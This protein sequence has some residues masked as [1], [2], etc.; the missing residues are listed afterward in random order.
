MSDTI[1]LADI[2]WIQIIIIIFFVVGPLLS[3]LGKN[4][5]KPAQPP[6]GPKRQPAP[7]ALGR[8]KQL[9]DEIDRLLRQA[10]DAAARKDAEQRRARQAIQ[11]RKP[12]SVDRPAAQSP[13]R[14]RRQRLGAGVDQHVQEHIASRPVTEHSATLGHDIE[15][16]DEQ[17]ERHLQNVFEHQLGNLEREDQAATSF[18]SK[19]SQGTDAAT[20]RGVTGSRE[21]EQAVLARRRTAIRGLFRDPE[22]IRNAFVLGEILRGPKSLE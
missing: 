22:Q 11:K 20:W 13:D 1:V 15:L 4:A 2:N 18:T 6:R 5:E 7:P 3:Q 21:K 9:T 17:V 10:T 8:P 14:P 16:A 12:A 19:V